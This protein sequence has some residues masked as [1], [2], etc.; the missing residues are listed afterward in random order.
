MIVQ[1]HVKSVYG[2]D[3]IYPVNDAAKIFCKI[4]GTKTLPPYLT[5]EIVKLGFEI[6][7]VAEMPRVVA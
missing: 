4:A 5:K 7:H 3:L 6:E 1:V 2:N